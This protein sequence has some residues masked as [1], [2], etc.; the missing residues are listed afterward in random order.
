MTKQR[1]EITAF[2]RRT[3]VYSEPNASVDHSLCASIGESAPSDQ[4][5]SDQRIAALLAD[6]ACGQAQ[7]S[8]D[9][10][11]KLVSDLKLLLHNSTGTDDVKYADPSTF[12]LRLTRPL[13][14]LRRRLRRLSGRTA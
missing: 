1:I 12:R 13:E 8:P 4:T 11:H 7:L 5:L 3:A 10:A 2:R 14:T 6:S 9:Q